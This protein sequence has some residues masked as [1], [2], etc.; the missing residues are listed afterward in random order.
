MEEIKTVEVSQRLFTLLAIAVIII[1]LFML[2]QMMYQFKSLPQNLPQEVSV[3]GEGKAYAKPDVAI[4]SFGVHTEAQKSQ[5]AVNKN[6]QIMNNV[7]KSIREAGVEEKDIQTTLYNLAPMYDYTQKRIIFKGFSLDQQVQ[8]KIRNFD[9]INDILDRAVANGANT[10]G[11]LSF[12]VDDMEKVRAEARAK[13]I[14]Q[15]KEKAMSL[16]SQSGLQIEKLVNIYEDILSIPPQPIS[17]RGG[18][19]AESPTVAP[20]IQ[21]GQIEVTLKIVLTYRI[22]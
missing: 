2:G 10:I 20:Q 11:D 15:A 18:T 19:I 17:G 21:T 4:V 8:V 7:I 13:A 12:D 14:A 6:N 3:S 22:R 5:D 16:F 9:K 1:S